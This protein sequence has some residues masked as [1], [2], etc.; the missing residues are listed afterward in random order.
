MRS[1]SRAGRS[2]KDF[3]CAS[4]ST[5]KRGVQFGAGQSCS[6]KH[7]LVLLNL[8]S[9]ATLHPLCLEPRCLSSLCVSPESHTTQSAG[10]RI[11][12]MSLARHVSSVFTRLI[13]IPSLTGRYRYDLLAKAT[14][15]T[16]TGRITHLYLVWCRWNRGR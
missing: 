1:L 8:P 10:L 6:S 7:P 14:V 13:A 16:E 12:A 9:F 3:C 2:R 15:S 11:V 5:W 4:G